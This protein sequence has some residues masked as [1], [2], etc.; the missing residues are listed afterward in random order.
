MS[1]TGTEFLEAA[2]AAKSELVKSGL[3]AGPAYCG[4]NGRPLLWYDQFFGK[5]IT[6]KGEIECPCALRVGATQNALDVALVA[7]HSNA[8]PLSVPEGA[9]VTLILLEGNAP[10]AAFVEV[11][12]SV[13]VTAPV[14]G[15]TADPD[16]PLARF[17]L[18]AMKKPWCKVK[19]VIDGEI[20]GGTLD[21]ALVYAAR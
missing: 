15:M 13:C 16:M 6:P 8:G 19:L 18:G 17:A 20:T 5:G 11:G 7:S 10:D 2:R 21:A 14:G 12:P 1:I 9:T 4:D 3:R